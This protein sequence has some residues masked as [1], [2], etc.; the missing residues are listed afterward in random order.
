MRLRGHVATRRDETRQVLERQN[1]RSLGCMWGCPFAPPASYRP[2]RCFVHRHGV[3]RVR[4]LRRDLSSDRGM[5]ALRSGSFQRWPRSAAVLVIAHRCWWCSAF[6]IRWGRSGCLATHQ[7]GRLA[8][9]LS[10]GQPDG[11]AGLQ[12]VVVP[13]LSARVVHVGAARC[14]VQGLTLRS[15]FGRLTR[16]FSG[17][18]GWPA[19]IP[20]AAELHSR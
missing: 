15:T 5:A 4:A 3:G 16:R 6:G 2:G 13:P 12:G 19:A 9:A 7:V 10:T 14:S 1:L 8:R 20:A 18:Q 11:T 17:R